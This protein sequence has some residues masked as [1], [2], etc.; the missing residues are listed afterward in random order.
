MRLNEFRRILKRE[1]NSWNI[2]DRFTLYRKNYTVWDSELDVEY[3]HKTLD[4]ALNFE[5]DGIKLLTMLENLPD[6]YFDNFNYGGGSGSG[7]GERMPVGRGGRIGGIPKPLAPSIRNTS[8]DRLVGNGGRAKSVDDAIRDFDNAH[9]NSKKEHIVSIDDNGYVTEYNRGTSDE[10]GL[11]NRQKSGNYHTI[12]NHPDVNGKRGANFS[13]QDLK[14]FSS[15]KREISMTVTD[16]KSMFKITKG[17]HF[18]SKGF[19]QAV[20]RLEKRGVGV[21]GLKGENERERYTKGMNKWL[22]INSKRFGYTYT[23]TNHTSGQASAVIPK[24]NLKGVRV[25]K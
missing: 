19:D 20:K 11:F 12:H 9:R 1:I 2:N 17:S 14:T 18:D 8:T 13:S 21:G 5:V 7:S 16:S 6:D 10:V 3:T 15:N 4:E 22:K 24:S 25:T 23:A